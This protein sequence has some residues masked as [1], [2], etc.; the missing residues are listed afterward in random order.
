MDGAVRTKAGQ[1]LGLAWPGCCCDTILGL[2]LLRSP[3]NKG[4][5]P[6]QAV[7]EPGPHVLLGLTDLRR[8]DGSEGSF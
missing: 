5:V 8:F 1:V 4:G 6:Q 7:V 2:L 3:T